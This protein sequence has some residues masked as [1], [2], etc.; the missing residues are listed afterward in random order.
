MRWS[1][2]VVVASLVSVATACTSAPDVLGPPEVAP[3]SA[4]VNSTSSSV[5]VS[6]FGTGDSY[7]GNSGWTL[8]WSNPIVLW[9]QSVSNAFV[10]A[11]DV[12]L[13]H[14]EVA[15]FWTQNGPPLVDAFLQ[16]DG[17]GKP[18]AVLEKITISGLQP[19]PARIYVAQS[20]T[21]PVLRAGTKYWMTLAAGA[22]G[23]WA[24]WNLNS[25]GDQGEWASSGTV[26]PS[27]PW[28]VANGGSRGAFRVSAISSPQGVVNAVTQDIQSLVTAGQLT[29]D[30][31][32]GLLDKLAA[33]GAGV[34]AGKTNSVC[35]QIGAFENQV[36]ALQRAGKLL[37]SDAQD[38][39]TSAGILRSLTGC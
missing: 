25:E 18:G 11:T 30:Q 15:L 38:L 9:D 5:I 3:P 29:T 21:S 32:Q 12:R 8:S 6:N 19:P 24:A 34:N 37:S 4:S 31:A 20:A 10:P 39:L 14:V 28:N 7:V 17:G 35:G 16:A 36:N 22:P 1:L 23:T 27:G 26:G 13:S 2:R 33:I